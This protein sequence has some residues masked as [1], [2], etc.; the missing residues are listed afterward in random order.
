VR[1]DRVSN[2]YY[3]GPAKDDKHGC[4]LRNVLDDE[5]DGPHAHSGR[6]AFPKRSRVPEHCSD[7][8]IVNSDTAVVAVNRSPVYTGTKFSVDSIVL[9]AGLGIDDDAH[10]GVTVKHR[11]DMRRDPTRVNVRQVHLIGAELFDDLASNGL[12]IGPGELGENITTRGHDLTLLP[13]GTRLHIGA[14]VLELTGLRNPC[15]LIEKIRPGLRAATTMK[16]NGAPAVRY[17]VMAIVIAGGE[18]SAGD[19]IAI[20]MPAEPHRALAPV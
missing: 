11:Y 7:S 18:I 4:S 10:A 12:T 20:D 19:S 13:A 16:R 15:S 17:G 5:R 8:T 1:R 3:D 9:R 6:P 14:A 2:R